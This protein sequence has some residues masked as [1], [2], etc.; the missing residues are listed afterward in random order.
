[1]TAVKVSDA[2]VSAKTV[3]VGV[4]NW[5]MLLTGIWNVELAVFALPAASW[6][7]PASTD[8]EADPD[9]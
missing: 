2:E 5:G 3:A 1:V 9:A 8:T 6:N 7:L 4:D